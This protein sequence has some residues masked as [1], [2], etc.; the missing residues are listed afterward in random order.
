MSISM[1]GESENLCLAHLILTEW[2]TAKNTKIEKKIKM[3]I[4]E[5]LEAKEKAERV[6]FYHRI[7]YYYS[8]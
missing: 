6:S 5:E 1:Q 2:H 7:L 4:L 3:G 8:L